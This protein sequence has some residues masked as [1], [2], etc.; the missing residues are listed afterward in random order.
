ML[1]TSGVDLEMPSDKG[2][3]EIL[4]LP[5]TLL[6]RAGNGRLIADVADQLLLN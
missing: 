4:E 5:V 3:A 1:S 6:S 2:V